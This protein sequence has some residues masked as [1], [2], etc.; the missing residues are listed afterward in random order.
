M[1]NGGRQGHGGL[2]NLAG[3]T[4]AERGLM[5]TY[6]TLH[7]GLVCQNGN[8]NGMKEELLR[9]FVYRL[10]VKDGESS[11]EEMPTANSSVHGL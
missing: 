7:V 10:L 9:D 8:L 1:N 11:D 2:T 6:I 3:K 5:L 4:R